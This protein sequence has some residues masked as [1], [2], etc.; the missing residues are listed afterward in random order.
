M[1]AA[2]AVA[3]GCGEKAEGAAVPE[4]PALSKWPCEEHD[5]SADRVSHAVL[6][7]ML[8]HDHI[9]FKTPRQAG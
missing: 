7:S 6:L 2:A 9:A 4:G 3:G 5:A 1:T 8:Y